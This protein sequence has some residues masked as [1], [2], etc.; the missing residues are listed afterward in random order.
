MGSSPSDPHNEDLTIF[1]PQ[2]AV[3]A[4]LADGLAL[5]SMSHGPYVEALP[6]ATPSMSVGRR[7]TEVHSALYSETYVCEE[8][9]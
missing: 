1:E 4:P 6:P 7:H 3:D 9:A 8:P 5:L 2:R